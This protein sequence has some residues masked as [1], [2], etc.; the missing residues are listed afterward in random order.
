MF[1]LNAPVIIRAKVK[2]W[3]QTLPWTTEGTRHSRS[4]VSEDC[5]LITVVQATRDFQSSISVETLSGCAGPPSLT[6]I[7]GSACLHLFTLTLMTTRAFSQ[8]IDKLRLIHVN[9]QESMEKPC[10]C[11]PANKPVFCASFV[12]TCIRYCKSH[13]LCL[14]VQWNQ[15]VILS[16]YHL[17]W[18]VYIGSKQL[19]RRGLT[20]IPMV[21]NIYS[22]IP[23]L[24][25]R[26]VGHSQWWMV[27]LH[28][29]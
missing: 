11:V 1:R 27:P 23:T 13:T 6:A 28:L 7:N 17:C 25:T 8:N 12:R 16:Y 20:I 22:L 2:K 21:H 14:N 9:V 19:R 18:P 26:G 10:K 4:K 5:L 24:Q 29:H 3:E 15:R